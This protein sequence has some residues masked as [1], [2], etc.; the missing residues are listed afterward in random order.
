MPTFQT[1][2]GLV[3]LETLIHTYEVYKRHDARRQ[4]KRRE[5]LQT[6]QGKIY[7]RQKAKAYYEKNKD[8]I[9]ERNRIRY[10]N[11]RLAEQSSV[12]NENPEFV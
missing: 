6:E 5:F 9:R 7:N 11:K 12:S 8:A 4:E 3:D 2:L 1:S 10:T